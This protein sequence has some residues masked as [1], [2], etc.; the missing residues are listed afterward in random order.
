MNF[1]DSI[2]VKAFIPIMDCVI[3]VGTFIPE[4][5]RQS[6][7]ETETGTSP[8]IEFTFVSMPSWSVVAGSK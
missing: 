5:S 1:I 7:S 2:V 8:M 6:D 4:K 3:F